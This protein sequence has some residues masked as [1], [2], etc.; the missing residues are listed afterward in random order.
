M[1]ITVAPNND[2]T[3]VGDHTVTLTLDDGRTD[4]SLGPSTFQLVIRIEWPNDFDPVFNPVPP[5]EVNV[6]FNESQ[7]IKFDFE[8]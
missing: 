2:T 5:S 6:W 3:L 8:D 7:V 1:T 4:P